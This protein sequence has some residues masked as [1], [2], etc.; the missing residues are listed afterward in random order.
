MHQVSAGRGAS[1]P[2]AERVL[3][4]PGAETEEERGPGE[5]PV[6]HTRW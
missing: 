2:S 1:L 5:D 3:I 6:Q 4:D